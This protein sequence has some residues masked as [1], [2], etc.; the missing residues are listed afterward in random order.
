MAV[1]ASPVWE[2]LEESHDKH[3]PEETFGLHWN[4]KRRGSVAWKYYSKLVC[5]TLRLITVI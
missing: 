1:L 5:L 4:N 2:V 3:E